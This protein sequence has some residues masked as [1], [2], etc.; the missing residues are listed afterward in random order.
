MQTATVT[1]TG[2][3]VITTAAVKVAA[4]NY[5]D[6]PICGLSHPHL[7]HNFNPSYEADII[8]T[9]KKDFP[10]W[11]TKQG[12]CGRCFDR[13]EAVTYHPYRAPKIS[14]EAFKQKHFDF[15]I[16]PIA[17]RLN[18][19]ENYT[20]KDVTI[21]FIDSGFYLHPDIKERVVKLVD[22]TDESKTDD[23][24]S[25]INDNA[26]HGTMTST[27]CAGNGKLSNGLYKG[28]APAAN[29]VLIKTQNDTGKI[30]DENIAKALMWV[31]QNHKTYNI[32]IVNL[33]LSGDAAEK[34][35]T[36]SINQFAEEL[37]NEDVLIV[38]AVGNDIN[39]EVLP[40][41]SGPHVVAVG[42]LD[43]QNKLDGDIILYHS[44]FGITVDGLS[45]PELISNAIWL[46]APILPQTDA[47]KK[48]TVLFQA[49]ENE[50]YMQAIIQN[51]AA[52]LKDEHFNL[53]EGKEKIWKEV[54]MTIWKEKFI[55]PDY[56][57]VDGTSFPAPIVSSVAAQMLEAN[58]LLT[59]IEIRDILLK[60]AIPLP[61]YDAAHQGYGRLQPKMAVYAVIDR[62]DVHFSEDDP[63]INRENNS[64]TFYIHLPFAKT[65]VSLSASF[66]NWKK[67]EIL[68]KPA[69]NNIWHVQIPM[70]PD[71][72]HEYKYFVDNHFWVEDLANPWRVI[73]NY[74]G[75]NNV[76]KI[77]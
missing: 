7:I 73:D 31:K 40:P 32:K 72:R 61:P 6:C 33:S 58:P 57:H 49:L 20:G 16:L 30:T 56:M 24:F 17:A 41:A 5:E 68:L 67:N 75:W 15:Y 48:A 25:A 44:S 4:D 2:K 65:S 11:E 13:F 70:L 71:G 43:D 14:V 29:L 12:I 54:K 36:S 38:A 1:T 51:N 23:Y 62:E 47:Q 9:V 52:S 27:V 45:K 22:I 28:L 46:P 10:A 8:S 19:D 69:K 39:A 63:I 34:S 66:N 42:G 18:A 21:C 74:G 64:I 3:K 37:F 60:T 26:W 35:A 55:T 76:F 53:F 77:N 59:A 50:D